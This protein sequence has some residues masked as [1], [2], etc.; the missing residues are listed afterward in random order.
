MAKNESSHEPVPTA[1]AT[2]ATVAVIYVVCATSI[3]LAP[4]LAMQVARSWFHGI[5]LEEISGWN[6]SAESLV[7]GFVTATAGAWLLGFV[8]ATCY[9]YFARK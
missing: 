3:A 6:L 1:N 2:A 9:N 7:L 4:D 5:R 8:F